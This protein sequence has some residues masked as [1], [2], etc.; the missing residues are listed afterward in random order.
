MSGA[1]NPGDAR[2]TEGILFAAGASPAVELSDGTVRRR[3]L[4]RGGGLMLVEVAFEPGAI[5]AEHRHPHDQITY[6]LSG[7]FEYR[8]EDEAGAM[9]TCTVRQGDSLFLRGGGLHGTTCLEK[10]ILL[11]IFTPQR[12]D[13]L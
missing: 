1:R 10:G 7:A 11:D 3:V 8:I 5:G 6:V 9:R 12:E 2:L 4:A 13:F